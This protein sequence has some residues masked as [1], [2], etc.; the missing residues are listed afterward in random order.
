[1]IRLKK[2][3]SLKERVQIR[4]CGEVFHL[5]SKGGETDEK[6]EIFSHLLTLLSEEENERAKYFY[7]KGRYDDIYFLTLDV[8]GESPADWDLVDDDGKIDF[9]KRTVF[10]HMLYLDSLRSPFNV[11]SIFRSS[12]A[13]AIEKI[14]LRPGSADPRHPRALKSSKGC[15]NAIAYSF[16]EL[17]EMDISYPV[18]ALE[19]GGEDIS[20]FP[21]PDEGLCIIGN[22]ESG[23]SPGALKIADKSLGRVSIRQY[24]AKGSINVASATSIMLSYWANSSAKRHKDA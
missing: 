23:I 11:G 4:K 14:I 1:M 20:T 16:E 19:V 9:S 2:I 10:H 5:L 3:K 8:L 18:F 6:E 17:E 15:V 12:E 21:F 24:G 22:E 13:F 7:I